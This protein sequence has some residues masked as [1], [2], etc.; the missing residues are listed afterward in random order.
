MVAL[1]LI[2]SRKDKIAIA[3]L[4]YVGLPQAVACA[5]QPRWKIQRDSAGSR[6]AR[7][8]GENPPSTTSNWLTLLRM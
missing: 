1:E 3:G 4:G 5:R 8:S 6:P 2:T 7:H